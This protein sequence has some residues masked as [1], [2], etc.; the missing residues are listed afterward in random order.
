MA[1][2]I[3]HTRVAV[4]N[5]LLII[6]WANMANGD[7]GDPFTEPTWADRNIQ[8]D[9]TFGA[10][11]TLKLQGSNYGTLADGVRPPTLPA[12]AEYATLQGT[13]GYDISM[14]AEGFR[15]LSAVPLWTRPAVTA[16]D[17]TTGIT[18]KMVCRRTK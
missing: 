7:V 12:E 1:S 4:G 18:V 3:N 11:G 15:E 5:D 13:D 2:T 6:T 10:G 16:G 17:G 14:T 8:A 9:G